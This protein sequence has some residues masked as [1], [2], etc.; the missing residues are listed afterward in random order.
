MPFL[1]KRTII[2]FVDCVGISHPCVWSSMCVV[3][4][5]K[6]SPSSL[7]AVSKVSEL[8]DMESMDP[9]CQSVNKSC[10]TRFN[11]LFH[12]CSPNMTLT[13]LFPVLT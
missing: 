10:E 11:V 8:M 12:W 7:A 9:R 13:E 3:E 5:I 4:W 2:K 1:Q 6:M